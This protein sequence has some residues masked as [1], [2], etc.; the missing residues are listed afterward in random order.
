VPK[1]R[2]NGWPIISLQI[3]TSATN[4]TVN[5]KIAKVGMNVAKETN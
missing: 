3:V 1:T 2:P 5:K 4:K